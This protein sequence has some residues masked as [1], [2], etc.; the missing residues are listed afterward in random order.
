MKQS[1]AWLAQLQS[2]FAAAK[3]VYVEA[4]ETTYCQAISKYQQTVEKS[5]KAMVAVIIDLG[6]DF[7]LPSTSHLPDREIEALLR[8][9]RA[10]DNSSVDAIKRIFGKHR[11]DI[12]WLCRLAPSWRGEGL[13]AVRNTEYPFLAGPNKV[14]DWTVPA[15]PDTFSRAEVERARRITWQFHRQAIRFAQTVKRGGQQTKD[16]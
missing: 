4:D 5:V 15:S 6:I 16:R 9:S 7:M 8:L 14:H 3:R 12:E 2:D 10:V 13:P 11:N 1:Q